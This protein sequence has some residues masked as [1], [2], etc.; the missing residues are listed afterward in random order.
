MY[1]G[2][3]VLH[4]EVLIRAISPPRLARQPVAVRQRDMGV[5]G[6]VGGRQG[7]LVVRRDLPHGN[8]Q[9]GLDL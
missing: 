1:R 3:V 2:M 4:G 8:A 5:R 7:P 6:R 9:P